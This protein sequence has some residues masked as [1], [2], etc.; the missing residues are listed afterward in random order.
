MRPSEVVVSEHQPSVSD[1][2]DTANLNA[3]QVAEFLGFTTWWVYNNAEFREKCPPN[4]IGRSLRWPKYRV[5]AYLHGSAVV[6][7]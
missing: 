5:V 7:S 3:R 2:P 4:R 6:G 1:L